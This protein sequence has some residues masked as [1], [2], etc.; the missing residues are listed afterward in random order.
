MLPPRATGP[1]LTE[2]LSFIQK[3]PRASQGTAVR[4][5]AASPAVLPRDAEDFEVVVAMRWWVGALERY[6]TANPETRTVMLQH[7]ARDLAAKVER[8][9]R[10][11]IE[12]ARQAAIAMCYAGLEWQLSPPASSSPALIR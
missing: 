12:T 7:V 4:S 8:V 2:C 6:L 1:R 9:N 10:G 11:F 5:V 3:R